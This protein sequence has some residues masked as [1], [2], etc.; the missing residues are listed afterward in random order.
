MCHALDT[1]YELLRVIW[2][3]SL[4]GQESIMFMCPVDDEV[5]ASFEDTER[6]RGRGVATGYGDERKHYGWK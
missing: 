2:V 1:E 5:L 4:R 3:P 6:R